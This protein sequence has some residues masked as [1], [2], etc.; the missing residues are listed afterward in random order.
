MWLKII[1][2]MLKRCVNRSLFLFFSLFFF[3]FFRAQRTSFFYFIPTHFLF[4][5][6]MCGQKRWLLTFSFHCLCSSTSHLFT[7]RLRLVYWS[8]FK[9]AND[10]NIIMHLIMHLLLFLSP[11][12]LIFCHMIFSLILI[13]SVFYLF[14]VS[15]W[16]RANA[17]NVRLYYPYRQYT[18][19]FIFQFI[20][21]WTARQPIRI[22]NFIVFWI[23]GN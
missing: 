9:I 18:N 1:V 10:L 12:W 13:H 4:L 20:K 17:R 11:D 5:S 19:L 8:T 23:W 7:S 2:L 3:S 16:R 14:S 22:F 21:F 6:S 15:L